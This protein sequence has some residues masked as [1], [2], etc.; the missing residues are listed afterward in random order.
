MHSGA[1]TMLLQLVSPKP[2]IKWSGYER[3]VDPDT[4]PQYAPESTNMR[5]SVSETSAGS[6]LTVYNDAYGSQEDVCALQ[7]IELY[8]KMAEIWS[9]RRDGHGH[10]GSVEKSLSMRGPHPQTRGY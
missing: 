7:M 8:Y 5:Y 1:K 6:D 10:G 2:S 4:V 9:L 3:F